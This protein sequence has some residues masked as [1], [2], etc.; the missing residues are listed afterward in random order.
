MVHSGWLKPGSEHDGR[1]P[2][3]SFRFV[4]FPAER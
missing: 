2:L 4:P 1:L 3:R